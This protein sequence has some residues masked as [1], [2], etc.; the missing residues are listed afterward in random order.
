MNKIFLWIVL[1]VI[2]L[3]LLLILLNTRMG[4][5]GD[6]PVPADNSVSAPVKP[7]PPVAPPPRPRVDLPSGRQGGYASA[8]GVKP[9][10]TGISCQLVPSVR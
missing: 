3:G 4:Q 9:T 1:A 10:E 2:I 8:S 7:A 6:A 5:S